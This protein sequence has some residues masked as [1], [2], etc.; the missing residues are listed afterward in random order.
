VAQTTTS[1]HLINRRM[2]LFVSAGA[3]VGTLVSASTPVG[4]YEARLRARLREMAVSGL[5]DLRI[6]WTRSLAALSREERAALVLDFVN[7]PAAS[8][9]K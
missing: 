1:K 5:G 8:S 2:A 3:L 9:L 7:A 4:P 6:S